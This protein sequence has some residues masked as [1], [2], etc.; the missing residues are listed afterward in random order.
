MFG[1]STENEVVLGV[2]PLGA[3]LSM[4]A[5]CLNLSRTKA[6]PGPFLKKCALR[7]NGVEGQ[8]VQ[9]NM[10]SNFHCW[11]SGEWHSSGLEIHSFWTYLQLAVDSQEKCHGKST[12]KSHLHAKK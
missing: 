8:S 12:R 6:R 5:L 10:K 3:S 7:E 2:C 9:L 1:N 4:F 11:P